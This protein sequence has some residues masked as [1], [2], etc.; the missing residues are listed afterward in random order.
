MDLSMGIGFLAARVSENNGSLSRV[1][2]NQLS[3][4]HSN[5]LRHAFAAPPITENLANSDN[6][7]RM[8]RRDSQG[9]E[10]AL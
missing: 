2:G 6:R 10:A 8:I 3:H 4:H 7:S 1:I 5:G 9:G